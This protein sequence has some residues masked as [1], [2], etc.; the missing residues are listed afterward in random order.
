M[1][2][3][4]RILIVDDEPGMRQ[5]A[6]RALRGFSVSIP[7]VNGDVVFVT[8]TAATGEDA[9][10][11]LDSCD[12]LLL[13]HKLPGMTGLEVLNR[14]TRDYPQLLTIMITAY[15]SLE[16]AITATKLGAYDFLAKP[17]TPEE[18]KISVRKAAKHLVLQRE[19]KRLAEE[20]KRI[21]FQFISVLAHE[22]K[23]PLNAIEG[24]LRIVR[25][26]S[27]GDDPKAYDQMLDRS[28]VRLDGM[29]K[30]IMDL[31]DMTR[32]ESGEKKREVADLDVV[33]IARMS[34]E[35]MQTL[36][37]ERKIVVELH[38]PPKAVLKGDRGEIEIILNNLISNAV[39]YN[40]DEGRVDVTIQDEPANVTLLVK[41]TGIGMTEAESAQ[42]FQEFVR[43]KNAKTRGVLG[44]GLGLSILKK[45]TQLYGGDVTVKSEPDVGS[46]FTAVLKKS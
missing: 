17:F 23:A 32:I 5:G 31:L 8:D 39:K 33:E 1:S 29:R 10:L 27:A 21:R 14:V 45:L 25:E 19:A 6:E 35:T 13:D 18:L 44:T 15:A 30:L 42:L 46:T 2:Q 4:V 40:R 16:T 22:L 41:D 7:E 36:A 3:N 26:K 20:K 9:L 38:A 37:R 11:K 34:V 28:I 43:I 12:L 24:N